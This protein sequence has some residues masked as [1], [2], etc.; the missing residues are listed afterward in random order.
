MDN[1]TIT[2]R[3]VPEGRWILED[4]IELT[5]RA[6]M[7]FK[8]QN[9]EAWYRFTFKI[10]ENIIPIVREKPVKCLGSGTERTSTTGRA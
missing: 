1:L 2:A 8:Q 10:T 9:P 7:E 6:I 4:L 3:S 5:N